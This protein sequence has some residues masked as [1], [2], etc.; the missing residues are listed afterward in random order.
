MSKSE[1]EDTGVF[2][3]TKMVLAGKP[4]ILNRDEAR[5]LLRSVIIY[6]KSQQ[7]FRVYGFCFLPD[8]AHLIIEPGNRADLSTIMKCI[9]GNFTRKVNARWSRKGAIMRTKYLRQQLETP[10]AVAEELVRL[11]QL[12]ALKKLSEPACGSPYSSATNYRRGVGDLFV[13]LYP[14]RRSWP[15]AA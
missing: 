12:P 4:K 8:R 7:L 14:M 6:Y 13:D 2:L 15:E 11:H 5:Y 3:T 9:W 10:R 1:R